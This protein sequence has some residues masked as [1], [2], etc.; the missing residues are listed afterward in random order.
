MVIKITLVFMIF[1]S[2]IYGMEIDSNLELNKTQE[3]EN[4]P[5]I[6]IEAAVREYNNY[7]A[8]FADKQNINYQSSKINY[9]INVSIEAGLVESVKFLMSKEQ[10]NNAAQE[11]SNYLTD[12]LSKKDINKQTTRMIIPPKRRHKSKGRRNAWNYSAATW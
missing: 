8:Q 11:Y 4:I 3:C 12:F 5:K 6:S 7:L 10:I 9:L 1:N 2:L